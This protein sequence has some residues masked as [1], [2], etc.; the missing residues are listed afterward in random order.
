MPTK[1]RCNLYGRGKHGKADEWLN[2][3]YARVFYNPKIDEHAHRHGLGEMGFQNVNQ[4]RA[5]AI[6]FSNKV[7]RVNHE[8][9]V[10]EK[11]ATLKYS[12]LTG[13]FCVVTNSGV[14]Y[15]YFKMNINGWKGVKK[16]HGRI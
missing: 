10:S 8:S 5:A 14:V 11:G 9:F 12:H 15:T 2:F 1:G 7:D 6:S 16:Q 3:K 4:Y 13:E